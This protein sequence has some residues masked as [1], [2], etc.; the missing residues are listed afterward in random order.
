MQ[1]LTITLNAAIDT[2]LWLDRFQRGGLNRVKR[3]VM[4][5][6]GKGNNVAKVLH[7]LGHSV[8]ASGF[9]AGTTGTFIERGLQAMPGMTTAFMRVSGE[10]RVCLTLL[11]EMEGTISELLEP[12]VE[13]SVADAH[14]FLN[15]VQRIAAHADC[16]VLSG[17]LPTGLPQDY[18]AQI[19]AALQPLSARLVLDTSG[20]PLRLGLSGQPHIIK[21]NAHEMAEL[22][23]HNGTLA[24]MVRFA[25][26]ELIGPVL[27]AD[28]CILLS[29]GDKGAALIKTNSAFVAEPPAVAVVNPVGAG[30]ALLAGFIDAQ[31]RMCD[32]HTS[33]QWAVA[34]GTASTLQ[35]IAGIVNVSDI[36][37]LSR[38]VQVRTLDFS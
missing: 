16:V 10:S 33:L 21:P 15:E 8:T 28:S 14:R 20:E 38:C 2:S 11:E 24:D 25:Q 3:K 4:V 1:C 19:L 31:S 26:H 12:G 23:E 7:T 13:I 30:D 36:E 32:D 22:M 29:L 35:E 9:I 6:G 37:K 34:A 17:S 18:Y 5:P 27:K